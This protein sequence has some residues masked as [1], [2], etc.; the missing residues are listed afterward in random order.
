MFR[1]IANKVH[2]FSRTS[3]L[4]L[5]M[6]TQGLA[7]TAATMTF[8][9]D[10]LVNYS[11]FTNLFDLY[12]INAV[13]VKFMPTFNDEPLGTSRLGLFHVAFDPN[14]VSS[15]SVTLDGVLQY[16]NLKTRRLDQMLTYYCK[17]CIESPV[18]NSAVSSGYG[19]TR[20]WID[21]NN[22]SVPHYGLLLAYQSQGIQTPSWRVVVTYY[23]TT[24]NVR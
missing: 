21:T 22:P 2:K 11:E 24:K 9:L 6:D 3:S 20:R 14:G 13:R 7:Q 4:V 19:P 5:T 23:L 17:P 8:S 18:Y 12:K 1:G 15:G 10:Q 16:Q